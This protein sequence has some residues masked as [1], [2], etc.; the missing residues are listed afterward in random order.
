MPAQWRPLSILNP[1]AGIIE[2]YQ[3]CLL[4]GVFDCQ[5]LSIASAA[6]LVGSAFYFRS[7]EKGFA[8][9]FLIEDRAKQFIG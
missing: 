2:A 8:D 4:G 9:I 1:M 7:V 6:I 5:S 3:T